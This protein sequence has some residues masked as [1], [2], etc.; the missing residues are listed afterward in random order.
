[1]TSIRSLAF[2]NGA[3]CAVFGNRLDTVTVTAQG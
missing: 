1:M 3:P 2:F